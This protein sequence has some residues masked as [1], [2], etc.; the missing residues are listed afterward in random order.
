[1]RGRGW[2]LPAGNKPP[3]SSLRSAIYSTPSRLSKRISGNYDNMD[4]ITGCLQKAFFS[5]FF[6]L[7]FFFLSGN[8]LQ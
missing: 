6:F 3:L 1:M 5:F 2:S 7:C 8:S 4:F